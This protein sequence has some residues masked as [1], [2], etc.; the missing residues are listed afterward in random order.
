MITYYLHFFCFHV[1]CSQER[2]E[3]YKENP[4]MG[5]IQG[6]RSVIKTTTTTKRHVEGANW[7]LGEIA[8]DDD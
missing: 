6:G 1:M 3:L 5:H 8:G 4:E 7:N 2:K